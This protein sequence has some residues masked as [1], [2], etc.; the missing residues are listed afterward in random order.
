MKDVKR[1]YG[2]EDGDWWGTSYDALIEAM[3]FDEVLLD[4]SDDDYQGDSFVLVYKLGQWGF[5]Q[6]GWGSCS[7][8]DAAQAVSSQEEANKL[9]DD[10]YYGI[11]WFDNYQD[12]VLWIESGDH[13]L[14]W[15]GHDETFEK[16]FAQA[17]ELIEKNREVS[18]QELRSVVSSIQTVVR[19]E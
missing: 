12:W 19:S 6:Y 16:F 5:L 13:K 8:C 10:L 4:V 7:G 2:D 11:K 15:Y 1:E 18:D 3:E 9:R 14:N 17:T